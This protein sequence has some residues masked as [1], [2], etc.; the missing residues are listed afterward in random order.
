MGAL[1]AALFIAS[2]EELKEE[3]EAGSQFN[4][5]TPSLTIRRFT[6]ANKYGKWPPA[7]I[8]PRR[9]EGSCQILGKRRGMVNRDHRRKITGIK[10]SQPFKAR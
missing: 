5:R 9:P 8:G 4:R 2:N 7:F 10:R 1:A 3:E 6:R